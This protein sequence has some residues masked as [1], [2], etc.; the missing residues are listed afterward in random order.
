MRL[1]I[2]ASFSVLL[3]TACDTQPQPNDA[4]NVSNIPDL[5]VLQPILVGPA[6]D[7]R[8]SR[9][10]AQQGG[11]TRYDA[12]EAECN[13]LIQDGAMALQ[14]ARTAASGCEVDAD[15]TVGFADT[16]CGGENRFPISFA[17]RASFEAE[18]D[19]VDH[20][21]CGQLGADCAIA[22][23]DSLPVRAVCVEA[24]CQFDV[25]PPTE[26]TCEST[27]AR[28]TL[29]GCLDC[30]LAANKA[31][32]ALNSAVAELNDCESDADC[33]LVS[34]DT[35]CSASCGVAIAATHADAFEE[36]RLEATADYCTG[37]S[38]PYAAPDCLPQA[39]VCDA[40]QC[41]VRGTW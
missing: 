2:I 29:E 32:A 8:G 13:A 12:A 30:E 9:A 21:I 22:V 6:V 36:A 3:A 37:G 23:V 20:E 25:V 33:V 31:S 35:G 17:G 40:G 1:S 18:V 11:Y 38:C 34:D 24:Q 5:S 16:G 19:R 14:A 41:A 7:L 26:T 4:S 10:E 28:Q 27:Q 39:A 15:C